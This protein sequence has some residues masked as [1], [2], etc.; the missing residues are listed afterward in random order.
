MAL[1]ILKIT[2]ITQAIYHEV[3]VV[4]LLWVLI[5]RFADLTGGNCVTW[6]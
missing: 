6:L 4:V 5:W 2:L 1:S 3:A